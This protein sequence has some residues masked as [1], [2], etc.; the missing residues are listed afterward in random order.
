KVPIKI[1]AEDGGNEAGLGDLRDATREGNWW[2]A[3]SILRKHKIE[4]TTKI[5]N[6][7]ETMLHLAVGEGKNYFVQKLLN[8]IQNEQLIEE[9]NNKGQTAL[10][11][12]ALVGNKY[13]A[14][15]LVKKINNLLYVKDNL[16]KEP[17]LIA[18]SNN[19]ISTFA[20]LLEVTKKAGELLS[21]D[22][23]S[24][25]EFIVRLIYR[26][27]YDLAFKFYKL[28]L[29]SQK[30][31]TDKV[32]MAITRN[33][34]SDCSFWEALIYPSW[35]NA[36]QKVVKRSSSLFYSFK[37][38]YARAERTLWR[39]K[40]FKNNCYSWLLPE[41]VMLLLVPIAVLYPLSQWILLFI[42]VLLLPFYM[43]YSL[44]W[45]VLATV[46]VPIKDIEKRKKEYKEAKTFL[47]YTVG[48]LD[49]CNLDN[50]LFY[51]HIALEAVCLDVYEVL[52][53][54]ISHFTETIEYT[55]ERH[56][57]IQLA[58]IHRSEKVYN[59]IFYP[60]IKQKESYRT[61]KDYSG[62]N[63]LH[64]VGR[65]APSHE[66]SCTTG[67]ALQ[68]QRELQWREEVKKFL[69]PMQLTDKN[70]DNETPE[71]VFTREHANLMKD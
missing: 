15:L 60:L 22:H 53:L 20:Y 29:K 38:M 47:D 10:H 64:L 56:N 2:R 43:L 18:Y 31:P 34:P 21:K 30:S 45:K 39:M 11:I 58:I 49:S 61:L 68:L 48:H 55:D 13:A 6:V 51:K 1:P 28:C 65:L 23:D 66:L 25:D 33:F 3:Q 54:I 57:I 67:A 69:E 7:D 4:L 40:R 59:R 42:S 62:N 52:R 12:A 41:I 63:L 70:I 24:F 27:E 8:S 32:L 16:G 9:K 71:E 37:Y 35:E 19:Q 5:N 50:S 26:K 44:L 36:G 14:D 46:V 17:L